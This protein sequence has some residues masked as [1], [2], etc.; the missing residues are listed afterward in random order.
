[1]P[2]SKYLK[3]PRMAGLL[4][5]MAVPMHVPE[6][7]FGQS[8]TLAQRGAVRTAAKPA[9][10]PVALPARQ[11]QLPPPEAM[12][13]LIR[14]SIVA[15]SQ[16]NVTNNYAVLN[17]LGSQTFRANNPP[18]QLANVFQSFR[19]NQIDLTP[20]VYINP[21]LTV[22][23]TLDGG[24]MRLVGNFPSQPMQV[25]FDL[26]FE[27]DGGVWKLFGLGVNLSPVGR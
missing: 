22:Q 26:T 1:M 11:L 18:A 5:L 8:I 15:L 24:K 17:A 3:K 2:L 27:P 7:A 20:V 21:Q 6:V 16:A 10:Q 4:L 19:A 25:N 12:I 23:P 9:L 14:S 13:I